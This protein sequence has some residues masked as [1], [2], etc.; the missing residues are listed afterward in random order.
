MLSGLS[1]LSDSTRTLKMPE[2]APRGFTIVSSGTVA[3]P[4]YHEE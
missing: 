2:F 4:T 3:A 1:E